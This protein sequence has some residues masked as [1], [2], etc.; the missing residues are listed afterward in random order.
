MYSL[1]A[2]IYNIYTIS[3]LHYRLI[4]Q[5]R[6]SSTKWYFHKR[7]ETD[8]SDRLYSIVSYNIQQYPITTLQYPTLLGRN[9]KVDD[10]SLSW[11]AKM[12]F[13]LMDYYTSIQIVWLDTK[14]E[15]DIVFDKSLNYALVSLLF[16]N[17]NLFCLNIFINA[18]SFVL[19]R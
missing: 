3:W 6:L 8:A 15:L 14:V 4:V 11:F 5:E 19:C 12:S 17:V 16:F 2:C 9:S 1:R 13:R 10:K 18:P 7:K